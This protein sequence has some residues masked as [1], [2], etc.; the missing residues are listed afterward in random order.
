MSLRTKITGPF[1][2]A[3][4]HLNAQENKN[5][6][7]MNPASETGIKELQLR[8]HVSPADEEEPW[9]D[10]EFY[11]NDEKG[12]CIFEVQF[13]QGAPPE[14]WEGLVD[15]CQT[16]KRFRL[17]W[18]PS[19]GAASIH[20]HGAY[21]TFTVGKSGDGCGGEMSTSV[22]KA[23]CVSAFEK[24]AAATRSHQAAVSEV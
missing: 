15:A 13:E 4:P 2:Y 10:F 17:D 1:N 16:T 21:V 24:A 19:N 3:P 23:A 18:G 20:A 8:V 14:D 7:E 6:P 11:T 5:S 12:E 9:Q 22:P